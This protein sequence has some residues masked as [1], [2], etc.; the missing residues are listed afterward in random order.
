MQ[1]LCLTN[2]M[3]L[4]VDSG[5]PP[6]VLAILKA[7]AAHHDIRLLVGRRADTTD[8]LVDELANTLGITVEDFPFVAART[9]AMAKAARWGRALVERT[10]TWVLAE[11]NS[12]MLERAKELAPAAGAVV[13]LDDYAGLYVP[14][15]SRLP[16]CPPVVCDKH[17]VMGESV[18]HPADGRALA[19]RV[20]D[21]FDR[22]LVRSFERRYL[23]RADGVVVTSEDED[24]RLARVYGRHADAVVTGGTDLAPQGGGHHDGRSVLWMGHLAY[25]PNREGLLQFVTQA[26]ALLGAAGARLLIAGA[27]PPP[28]VRALED[29]PGVEVL[30]YVDDLD[31]LLDQVTV[32][33]VPLWRGAGVKLKTVTMMGA[34]IPVVTTPQGVEGLKVEDGIHCLVADTPAGLASA[35]R[36]L[37][38]DRDLRATLAREGRRLVSDN[39]TWDSVTAPFVELME[40]LAGDRPGQGAP[41]P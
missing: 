3:P 34:G 21:R 22:V 14:H 30:G 28:E 32:G 39:Y 24:Q 11:F 1:L 37:L 4:P 17:N 29:Q 23:A 36:R 8:D 27:Q 15:I 41:A 10:P 16:G 33:V 12:P 6:R 25:W 26:W 2:L 40:N 13:V 35:L 7:L 9:G 20:R 19:G 5:G 38:D 18:G 31:R